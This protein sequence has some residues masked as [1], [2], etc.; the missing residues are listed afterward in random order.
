[1]G[2]GHAVERHQARPGG[3]GVDYADP[4]F[5][6]PERELAAA[7]AAYAAKTDETDLLRDRLTIANTR[8]DGLAFG[9]CERKALAM[10]LVDRALRWRELGEDFVGAPAQDE[11]FVLSHCDSIQASGS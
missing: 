9:R 10:A 11:E 8:G 6:G 3:A 2:V 1:M 4:A 5:Q 7:K